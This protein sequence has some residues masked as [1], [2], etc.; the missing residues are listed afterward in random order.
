MQDKVFPDIWHLNIQG[1]L[2]MNSCYKG[3]KS[4]RVGWDGWGRRQ[5]VYH[6]FR[7]I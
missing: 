6:K 3:L 4:V 7:W 5:G 2:K 1:C